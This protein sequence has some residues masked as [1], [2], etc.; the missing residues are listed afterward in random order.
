MAGA[1]RLAVPNDEAYRGYHICVCGAQSKNV[2]YCLPNG[3]QTNSL[4]I[5]YVAHHRSEI[6]RSQLASI[7]AFEFGKAEPNAEE[8]QGPSLVRTRTRASLERRLG[9][10]R[11]E[12]WAEWG[13]D[14]EVLASEL[15]GRFREDACT[16]LELVGCIDIDSMD[17]IEA[18]I[19]QN[20]E[21]V[22]D[23]GQRALRIP[24][25][26]RSVWV[27][28]LVAVL[29]QPNEKSWRSVVGK[30][31]VL[32]AP[33]ESGVPTLLEVAKKVNA[34]AHQYDL[35]LALQ[36]IEGILG[37]SLLDQLP[38]K[39][40]GLPPCLYCQGSRKCYCIR[41]GASSAECGRCKGTGTC[42]V[43]RGVK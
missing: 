21:D 13:L 12:I 1:F 29:K 33:V 41:T 23:W 17:L 7:A 24:G 26:E 35:R 6:P 5:H 19:R 8:L 40:Y 10:Q 34:Q 39:L 43:C 22:R 36:S 32:G 38:S 42:H 11:L 4:C 3:K 18:T 20:H 14:F 31:F 15:Y 27:P 16:L 2:D 25:W 37:V 30:F 9:K 28:P